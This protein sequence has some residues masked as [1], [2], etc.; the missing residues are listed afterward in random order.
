MKLCGHTMGTP[1]KTAR[2]AIDLFADIGYEGIEVRC[3]PDGVLDLP[4]V[5]ES[6][7][8][9]LRD[10]AGERGVV[11]ACLTPYYKD[12][13]PPARDET[14]A[15][16]DLALK[17]AGWLDCPLVRVNAGVWPSESA[18]HEETW[19][20]TV[21]GLR[22]AGARAAD[23]GKR[24]A[25]ENHAGTLTMS[26]RDTVRLVE[27]VASPGV[28]IIYDH[29]FIAQASEGET[30]QEAIRLQAPHLVHVHVKNGREQDGEFNTCLVEDGVFDWPGIVAELNAVGYEGFLSDEWEK[31]W[32]PEELPDPEIGM[33]RNHDFL[34]KC[35]RAVC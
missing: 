13:L 18:T 28:G 34:R 29:Y 21:T 19:Q 3:A 25:V 20:A 23:L 22:Q 17:V 4:Q 9:A 6:E 11:F 7:A 33:R 10:Y 2:E 35:L 26:A 8:R 27:E 5:T 24:L 15:G 31:H 12:F 14:L 30:Y 32:R 16:L 1:G